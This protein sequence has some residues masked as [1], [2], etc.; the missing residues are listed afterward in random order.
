VG[1]VGLTLET[2]LGAGLGSDW[3]VSAERRIAERLYVRGYA[4]TRQEGRAL[5]IGAAY[6]A[7]FKLRW[8]LDLE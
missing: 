8:E 4:A 6:G 5:P 2:A 7:E 3:Y 1:Q